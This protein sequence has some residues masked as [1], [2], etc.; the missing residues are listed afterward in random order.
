VREQEAQQ[1]EEAQG[2]VPRAPPNGP[3]IRPRPVKLIIQ[4]PCLHE[5][6]TLPGTRADLPREVEGFDRVGHFIGQGDAVPVG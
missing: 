6:E 2:L 4:I 3:T 1:E 5:E